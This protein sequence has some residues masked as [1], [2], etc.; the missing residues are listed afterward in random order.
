[1]VALAIC[2]HDPMRII[3]DVAGQTPAYLRE[4]LTVWSDK[5]WQVDK[6]VSLRVFGELYK[7]MEKADRDSP[8]YHRPS[9]PINALPGYDGFLEDQCAWRHEQA[10]IS[11]SWGNSDNEC[12]VELD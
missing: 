11:D 3:E 1:M 8:Y 7:A 9:S 6:Q 10:I 5:S 4:V 2:A 12:D